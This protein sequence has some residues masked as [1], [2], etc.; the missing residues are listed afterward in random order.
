MSGYS[1]EEVLGKDR[2]IANP[3]EMNDTIRA[4]HRR[5]LAGEPVHLETQSVNKD[6]SRFEL[7]V[8]G[9]PIQYRGRP[10]VLYIGR[11][12]SERKRAEE[13]L[14]ASE[15]QY[16]SIFNATSGRAGAARRRGPGGGRQPG[17]PRHE[18]LQP[19]RGGEPDALVLR[20]PGDERRSR[21]RCTRA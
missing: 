16:R 1:R 18:R 11:D 21:S 6:G 4:L 2:L 13:A 7:E 8:R 15:E 17:V 14:R 19:R 10:H 12:I 9:V 5:A 3:P 20:R